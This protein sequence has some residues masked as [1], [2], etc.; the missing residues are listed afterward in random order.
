MLFPLSRGEPI[1]TNLQN[2]SVLTWE[3]KGRSY[4]ELDELY[5]SGTAPRRFAS[6]RTTAQD[7]AEALRQDSGA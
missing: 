1:F 5:E 7:A 4:A 2:H 3:T 6:A